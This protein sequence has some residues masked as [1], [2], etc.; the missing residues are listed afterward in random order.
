MESPCANTRQVKELVDHP[1]LFVDLG[2]EWIQNFQD[3]DGRHGVHAFAF[4]PFPV[5]DDDR[6][7]GHPVQL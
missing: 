7:A 6:D 3:R 4:N 2:F 5:G 1:G